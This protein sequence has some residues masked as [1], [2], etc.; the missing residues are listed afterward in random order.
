MRKSGLGIYEGVK[1]LVVLGGAHGKEFADRIFLGAGVTP[2]LALE[3]EDLGV[4]VA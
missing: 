4:T 1:Y 3:R 2:P